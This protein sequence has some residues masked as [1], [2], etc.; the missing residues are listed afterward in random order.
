MAVAGQLDAVR[1]ARP[2]IIHQ[3][4]RKIAIATANQE[5]ISFV[6]ASIAVHVHVSP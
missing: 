4:H 5:I 6:S 1:D 3:A 2:K